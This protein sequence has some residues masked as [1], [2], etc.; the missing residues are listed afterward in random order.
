MDDPSKRRRLPFAMD[1]GSRVRCRAEAW[2]RA[3]DMLLL[4]LMAMRIMGFDEWPTAGWGGPQATFSPAG[5]TIAYPETESAAYGPL[6]RSLV[7]SATE[8]SG[9]RSL[10]PD[11][12][13]RPA[14][15]A[16]RSL[17]SSAGRDFRQFW[18]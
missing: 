8:N 18:S 14:G 15:E 3:P 12:G 9:R 17:S 4:T 2:R 13:D 10:R 1:R 16:A 11:L 7:G 6:C 5:V